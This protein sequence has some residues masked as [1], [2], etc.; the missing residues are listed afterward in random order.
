MKKEE[1]NHQFLGHN[2]EEQVTLDGKN[3]TLFN[4]NTILITLPSSL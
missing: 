4:R 3:K 1:A 2:R